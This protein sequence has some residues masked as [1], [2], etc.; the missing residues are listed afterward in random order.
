MA[1][2]FSDLK[3]SM[4]LN[5]DENVN[6]LETL[7]AEA[8]Q[9]EESEARRK[10]EEKDLLAAQIREEQQAVEEN[11][12]KMRGEK[13]STAKAEVRL[14]KYASLGAKY[15]TVVQELLGGGVNPNALCRTAGITS[16]AASASSQDNTSQQDPGGKDVSLPDLGMGG[17]MGGGGGGG[18][19]IV[20]QLLTE[21]NIDNERWAAIHWAASHRSDP[22]MVDLLIRFGADPN[23]P[24]EP[25]KY[26]PLHLAALHNQPAII[27]MLV[28]KYKVN[29]EAETSSYFRMMRPL[30]VA[31]RAGNVEA[32]DALLSCGADINSTLSSGRT[33]LLIAVAEKRSNVVEFLIQSGCDIL[34]FPPSGKVTLYN[35]GKCSPS[36]RAAKMI[37]AFKG[38]FVKG[39]NTLD[40]SDCGL[41][42]VPEAIV[43][44][45]QL[46]FLILRN[47]LFSTI[48]SVLFEMPSVQ[49][50]DLTGNRLP[51]AAVRSLLEN[52]QPFLNELR[53]GRPMKCSEMKLMIVGQ[54]NVGKS[55]RFSSSFLL[56]F[57]LFFFVS[58]L[59]IFFDLPTATVLRWLKKEH[60]VSISMHTITTDGIDISSIALNGGNA[61]G[62]VTF[63]AWDFAG[64]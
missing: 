42:H 49:Q 40:L 19:G 63:R 53:K 64:F 27:R 8:K 12:S 3:H 57:S 45:K 32:V 26:T 2:P 36:S 14:C 56:L 51:I 24:T 61:S 54:E 6:I 52:P 38:V 13:S 16:S 23:L 33:A 17:G 50:I 39:K 48:P 5:L 55:A 4:N 31:A 43:M 62:G 11:L 59:W 46:K 25:Y 7:R 28:L 37:A 22:E 18:G 44:A 15:I 9:R 20:D 1:A 47:N 58:I 41:S 30:H 60:D 10:Q 35:V 29:I 21:G 34:K